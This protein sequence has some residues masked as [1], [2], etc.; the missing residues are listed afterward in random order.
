MLMFITLRFSVAFNK[1]LSIILIYELI[2]AKSL[3][4]KLKSSTFLT[5]IE[6]ALATLISFY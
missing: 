1:F 6:I 3:L 5:L 4:A 2:K